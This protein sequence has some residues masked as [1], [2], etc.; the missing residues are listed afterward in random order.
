MVWLR[1]LTFF[2]DKRTKNWMEGRN[3]QAAGRFQSLKGRKKPPL[4]QFEKPFSRSTSHDN[5][6]LGVAVDK[7]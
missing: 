6:H 2:A 3:G 1:S 4:K 5:R 7:G